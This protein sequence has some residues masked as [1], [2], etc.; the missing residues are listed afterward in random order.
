[1][2][3]TYWYESDG[4]DYPDYIAKNKHNIYLDTLL[5]NKTG[6]L[7]YNLNIS[8]R[9]WGKY[10]IIITEKGGH[11][12]GKVLYLN[13]PYWNKYKYGCGRSSDIKI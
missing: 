4:Y 2:E 6:K 12:C 9:N 5:Q 10:L 1:M 13:S 8:D 3:T 11:Q 7:N